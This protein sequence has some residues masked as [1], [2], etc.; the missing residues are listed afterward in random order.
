MDTGHPESV[1][2]QLRRS[3]ADATCLSQLWGQ[4]P[5]ATLVIRERCCRGP[6]TVIGGGAELGPW[7]PGAQGGLHASSAPTV[8]Q[9]MSP[10]AVGAA[11]LTLFP[12]CQKRE[13]P[14]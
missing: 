12:L 2:P 4:C 9:T 10:H 6:R 13:K 3:G 5:R 7:E 1:S 11:H 8:C 14:V